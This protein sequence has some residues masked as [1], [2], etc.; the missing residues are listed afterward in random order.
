MLAPFEMKITAM[1]RQPRGDEG[2]ATVMPEDL[3]V[4][5]ASADHVV[6]I[7]PENPDSLGFIS[8]E[9][10]GGMKPGIGRGKTVDQ[11]ALAASL[12]NGHLGA[13]WLDVTD[14]EPLPEG[15]P[16]WTA[17][18]CHITPH[19]AGGHADETGTMIRHFLDNFR[20]FVQGAALH[21]RIM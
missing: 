10:L 4:V 6:D 5:L 16:L 13:A 12:Q 11:A 8:A 7:L 21:D 20:R 3:P 18:R 15:H 2:V 14:P 17:P 19:T 1:R 9:R